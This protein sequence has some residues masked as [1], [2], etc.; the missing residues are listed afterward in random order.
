MGG[1]FSNLPIVEGNQFGMSKTKQ[2]KKLSFKTAQNTL[3]DLASL[4]S[5]NT[6]VKAIHNRKSIQS[7]TYLNKLF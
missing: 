1:A 2:E 4:Q 3:G 7:N 5:S 6:P